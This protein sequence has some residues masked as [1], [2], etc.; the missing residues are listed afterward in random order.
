MLW[1]VAIVTEST[2]QEKNDSSFCWCARALNLQT[3]SGG[4]PGMLARAAH[5]CQP[6]CREV[7][8]EGDGVTAACTP[9][10]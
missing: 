3:C 7:T 5:R 2:L 9:S 10:A 8:S 4:P 6:G 1:G